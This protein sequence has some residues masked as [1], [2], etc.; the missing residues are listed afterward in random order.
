MSD[1]GRS[2][3]GTELSHIRHELR[4]PINAIV[5]Y[6][7]IVAEELA[8]LGEEGLVKDLAKVRDAAER[9]LGMIDAYLGDGSP[10]HALPEVTTVETSS[11]TTAKPARSAIIGRVLIV[12]DVAE[13]RDI[14]RRYLERLGHT[15][16]DAA[17]GEEALDLAANG[18]FDAM[19]LDVMMPGM[20]GYAVLERMQSDEH[21]REIPVIMISA[22]DQIDSVVKC[23]ERGAVDYLA[24]PFDPVLLRARLDAC[25]EKKRLRDQEIDYLNAVDQVT[26]AAAAIESGHFETAQINH[27][28]DRDD[29]LGALARVFSRMAR[30]IEAREARLRS[31]VEQLRI[32]I[33]EGKRKK[34]VQAITSTDYFAGLQSRAAEFRSRRKED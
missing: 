23:I 22:L 17:T 13:N 8:D 9:L 25:L 16:V 5:G 6:S 21:L 1:A 26:D 3:S 15:V 30:E 7:E 34:E 4:T 28:Q 14:L 31:Q 19:L 32:E 11:L 2:L 33:D 27:L 12:D 29:A 10:G 24:K 18:H 20:D